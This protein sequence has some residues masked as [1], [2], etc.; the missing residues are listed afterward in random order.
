M[1]THSSTTPVPQEM[2]QPVLILAGIWLVFLW[3]PIGAMVER[4]GSA[5]TVALGVVGLV[6]FALTYLLSYVWWI[7]FAPR[8]PALNTTLWSLIMMVCVVCMWPAVGITTVTVGPYFVA[9]WMFQRTL[10]AGLVAFVVF[11]VLTV[12]VTVAVVPGP[13]WVSALSPLVIATL[14]QAVGR[15]AM[16]KIEAGQRLQT[17]LRLAQQREAWARDVHDLL[18]HSLSVIVVKSELAARLVERDAGRA[19][20]EIAEV[21]AIARDSLIQVRTTVGQLR[22]PELGA[23]LLA[24]RS[25]LEAAGIQATVPPVASVA[26]VPDTR[27]D[28]FAWCVREAVT[29]VV[30]HSGATECT[31]TLTPELLTVRDNGHGFSGPE[32]NGLCGL[33]ERCQAAGTTLRVDGNARP[34]T[35]LEVK[36]P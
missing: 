8:I 34:G 18:G 11:L 27:R 21:V 17:Q 5:S 13:Q 20:A 24:A 26:A 4:H 3:F 23:Q 14:V 35:L 31:I 28:L 12:L 22:T 7:P 30:R 2:R 1:T 6:V 15:L 29:N 16:D 32:G 36:V 25:A 19:Q 10:R 33:R 9:M